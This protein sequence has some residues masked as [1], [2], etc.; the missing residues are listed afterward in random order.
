M[1][2]WKKYLLIFGIALAVIL[3]F[4]FLFFGKKTMK[5]GGVAGSSQRKLPNLPCEFCSPPG[6]CLPNGNCIIIE[7]DTLRTGKKTKC[8]MLTSPVGT[9]TPVC[10]PYLPN[11]S[12]TFDYNFKLVPS[13]TTQI[14]ANTIKCC[15]QN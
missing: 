7:G 14:N 1:T 11:S 15:Y 6:I 5:I 9:A 13:L 2:P 4:Y 12:T 10:Y 3:L 8:I